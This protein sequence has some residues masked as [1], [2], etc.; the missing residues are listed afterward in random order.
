MICDALQS[1]LGRETM[2]WRCQ[3][4]G[5]ERL[6]HETLQ[7][8]RSPEELAD[9]LTDEECQSLAALEGAPKTVAELALASMPIAMRTWVETYGLAVFGERGEATITNDGWKVIGLAALRAKPIPD[10]SVEDLTVDVSAA[11]ANLPSPAISAELPAGAA[12]LR[13]LLTKRIR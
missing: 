8:D 6:T 7:R 12:R 13:K 5:E 9:A 4:S 10:L 2:G 1:K 3:M 11:L